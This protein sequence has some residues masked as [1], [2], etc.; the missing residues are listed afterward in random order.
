MSRAPQEQTALRVAHEILMSL[1]HDQQVTLGG[2][3]ALKPPNV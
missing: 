2:G 3:G 1:P